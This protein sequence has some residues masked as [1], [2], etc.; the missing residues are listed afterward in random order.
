VI[1]LDFPSVECFLASCT[2]RA[3]PEEYFFPQVS[4]SWPA[5]SDVEVVIAAKAFTLH[6]FL[7]FFDFILFGVGVVPGLS[8]T[9]FGFILGW[10]DQLACSVSK[11]VIRNGIGA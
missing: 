10:H 5:F 2:D 4:L 11:G 7:L 6:A 9:S 3:I 8:H 1:H